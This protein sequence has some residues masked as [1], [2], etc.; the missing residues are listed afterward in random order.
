[1]REGWRQ[2]VR[3]RRRERQLGLPDPPRRRET[4]GA[5]PRPGST[6]TADEAPLTEFVKSLLSAL[7]AFWVFSWAL[8]HF[9]AVRP[10]YTLAVLGLLYSVQATYYKHE[11]SVNPDF[12]IPGCRCGGAKEDE[13][14]T[15]LTSEGSA[16]LHIPNSVLGVGL[17]PVLLFLVSGGR[18]RAALLLSALAVLG[19][20]Y[21]AYRMVARVRA[22]C[23]LCVNVYGVNLWLLWYL[24]GLGG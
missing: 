16:I 15:V 18:E 23:S 8:S 13:T 17:Y 19:S 10:V 5:R 1:M 24:S 12:R 20:A 9:F 11:L 4:P 22:L 6:S 3:R 21:L 7:V 2:K 14:E